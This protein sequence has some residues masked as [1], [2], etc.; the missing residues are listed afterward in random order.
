V[1]QPQA[2]VLG[3]SDRVRF[4]CCWGRRCGGRV[5]RPLPN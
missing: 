2:E 1:G 3:R 5:G 4:H